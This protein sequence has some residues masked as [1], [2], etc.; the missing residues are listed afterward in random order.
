VTSYTRIGGGPGKIVVNCRI[1]QSQLTGIGRYLTDILNCDAGPYQQVMPKQVRAGIGGHVWEQF[2][3]PFRVGR[4]V[5]WSPSNTGPLLV[6]R[7][8]VTIH[9]VTTLD[10]PEWMG[11]KFAAWYGFLLPKLVLR[12]SHV[13]VVSE[14]TK[15]RLLAKTLI[16]ADKITVIYNGVD[17]KF[18]PRDADEVAVAVKAVGVPV[19]KYLLTVGSLEP[20]KNLKRLLA[21]WE[22]AQL[23]LPDDIWLVVAGAKGK[24]QVF[25]DTTG[26]ETLPPRVHLAG[27]VDDRLLPALYAGAAGF[28]YVS[29]YEGF[30]LPPVEAMASGVPVLVSD[31]TVFPEIIG[32]SGLLVDPMD[33]DS[34]ATGIVR[35]L[36]DEK[37]AADLAQRGLERAKLYTWQRAASETLAAL[38]RCE[39]ETQ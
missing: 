12:A 15:Q 22:Q 23:E 3:L 2:V 39:I 27:R 30:G 11:R 31:G 28:A 10:H 13:I 25:G 5:L 16:K 35:L 37:L 26:A 14:F 1:L 6:R 9:D 29:L 7:Q 19:K 18:H 8:V 38:R 24:A 33:V 21:A 4:A 36:T 32:D 20:R 34:I 17:A